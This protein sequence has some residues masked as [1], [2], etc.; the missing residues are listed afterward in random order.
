M[1]NLRQKNLAMKFSL[2]FQMKCQWG[3]EISPKFLSPG[4]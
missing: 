2:K 3:E 1:A 4:A